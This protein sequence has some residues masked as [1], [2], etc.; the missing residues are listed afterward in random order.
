ML[1]CVDSS[2]HR[3]VLHNLTHT[4]DAEVRRLVLSVPCKSSD[5]D[6]LPTSFVKDCID[7]LVSQ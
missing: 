2:K 5:L 7:I 3:E 4:T 1:K 6:P